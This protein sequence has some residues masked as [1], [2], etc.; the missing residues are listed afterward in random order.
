MSDTAG[1]MTLAPR[2]A[3]TLEPDPDVTYDC[4]YSTGWQCIE[5]RWDD[6]ADPYEQLVW[7]T[8]YVDDLGSNRCQEPFC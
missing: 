3:K 7:G 6:D 2:I 8:R 5:V 1:N 4:Y